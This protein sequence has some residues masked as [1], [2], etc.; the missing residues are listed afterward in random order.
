LGNP[1][2]FG[3]VRWRALPGTEEKICTW[4]ES[5]DLYQ[6]HN[7]LRVPGTIPVICS[8]H[9]PGH[10]FL[11]QNRQSVP[12]TRPVP[13]PKKSDTR[14][15]LNQP[16]PL[17]RHLLQQFIRSGDIHAFIIMGHDFFIILPFLRHPIG[18]VLAHADS[19]AVAFCCDDDVIVF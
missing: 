2:F 18:A 17:R 3:W 5:L 6:V 16:L 4:Y 13:A 10:L 9:K 19:M 14:Q 7:G 8:W 1:S 15:S 12:G 11:A